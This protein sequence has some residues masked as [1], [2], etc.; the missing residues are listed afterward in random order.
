MNKQE[1]KILNLSKDL[2]FLEGQI[3]GLLHILSHVVGGRIDMPTDSTSLREFLNFVCNADPEYY[4]GRF[5][6]SQQTGFKTALDNFSD[7]AKDLNDIG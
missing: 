4:E 5:S 7:F 6:E 2:E 3:F 1:A